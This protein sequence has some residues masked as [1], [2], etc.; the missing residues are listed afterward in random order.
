M[1]TFQIV[2]RHPAIAA[3]KITCNKLVDAYRLRNS[4]L[5]RNDVLY[6]T[7]IGCKP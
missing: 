4:A 3:C 7:P 5:C 2:F 1:F 6:T